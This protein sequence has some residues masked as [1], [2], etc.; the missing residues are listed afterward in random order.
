MSEAGELSLRGEHRQAVERIQAVLR[1]DPASAKAWYTALRIFDRASDYERAEACVRRALQLSPRADGWV[2]LARY[3]LNRGD[4]AGFEDALDEAERLDPLDG[5]IYIGRG[6]ALAMDRQ[7]ERAL[8]Q[9]EKALEVDPVRSGDHARRQIER[10][11]E[12]LDD[13]R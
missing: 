5:G 3:A 7:Y 11:R 2:A 13:G 1:E 9:F 4:R 6:H 8:L 10:L 12:F